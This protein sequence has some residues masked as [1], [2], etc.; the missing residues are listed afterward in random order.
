MEKE[1]RERLEVKPFPRESALSFFVRKRCVLSPFQSDFI[2]FREF[3]RRYENFTKLPIAVTTRPVP[4][5]K[6]EMLRLGVSWKRLQL[7]YIEARPFQYMPTDAY[8]SQVSL[9]QNKGRIEESSSKIPSIDDIVDSTD[10]RLNGG[11]SAADVG[12]VRRTWVTWARFPRT[13][14][15][16]H[17]GGGRGVQ[18]TW[19]AWLTWMTCG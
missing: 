19:L 10:V 7:R 11:G 16:S 6:R 15:H 2:T 18:R 17:L 14:C 1:R 9:K 8:L 5:T 12:E 3:A 4:V 13:P